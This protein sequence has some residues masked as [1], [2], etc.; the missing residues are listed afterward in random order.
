[1]ETVGN[2]KS[3][4]NN[5]F[6]VIFLQKIDINL[7]FTNIKQTKK[8]NKCNHIRLTRYDPRYIRAT[9]LKK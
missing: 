8:V 6:V 1:M 7:Y 2:F 4:N 3:R 5:V 9:S